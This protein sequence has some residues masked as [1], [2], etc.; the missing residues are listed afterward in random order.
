MIERHRGL[1]VTWLARRSGMGRARR[2]LLSLGVAHLLAVSLACTVVREVTPDGGPVV[3]PVP[4]KVMDLLFV[5]SLD[6]SASELA[7][8]YDTLALQWIDALSMENV[9]VRRVALAP[10]HRRIGGEVPLLG[11][12]SGWLSTVQAYTSGYRAP[13]LTDGG[14]DDLANL[15]W[16]G[17]RLVKLVSTRRLSWGGPTSSLQPTG[18]S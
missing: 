9:E 8:S 10:L 13:L 15:R 6:P 4:P 2:V 1:R 17:T 16:L 7:V 14:G 12:E 18:S 3:V 11:V 5:M